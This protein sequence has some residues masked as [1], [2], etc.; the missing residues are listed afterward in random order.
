M[1]F[2]VP[3]TL[4]PQS[5][6]DAWDVRI[7]KQEAWKE[8]ETSDPNAR[9]EEA[10]RRNF[11]KTE[12]P[13]THICTRVVFRHGMNLLRHLSDAAPFNLSTEDGAWIIPTHASSTCD[14]YTKQLVWASHRRENVDLQNNTRRVSATNNTI[15]G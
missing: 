7:A 3:N 11:P 1:C 2:G 10:K 13:A 6:S 9:Q 14:V 5:V 4:A 15:V 12:T 8:A